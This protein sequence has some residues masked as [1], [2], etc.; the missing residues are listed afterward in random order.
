LSS[1][2]FSTTVCFGMAT[3]ILLASDGSRR[4]IV[5]I[6]HGVSLAFPC[7]ASAIRLDE[8]PVTAVGR[9]IAGDRTC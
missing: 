6:T 9:L 8:R 4:V 1:R 7:R 2:A 5:E 3:D